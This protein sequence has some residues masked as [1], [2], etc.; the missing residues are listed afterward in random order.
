MLN[1]TSYLDK[2]AA[3]AKEALIKSYLLLAEEKIVEMIQTGTPMM[4]TDT[5]EQFEKLLKEVRMYSI[6]SFVFTCPEFVE[7]VKAE[8]EGNRMSIYGRSIVEYKNARD[9]WFSSR[10]E[11][12][13]NVKENN[14][15][16]GYKAKSQEQLN[17]QAVKYANDTWAVWIKKMT[18]KLDG[19]NIVAL[20]TLGNDPLNNTMIAE[21]LNGLRFTVNNSI[22]L[23]I[24]DKGTI[25]N[26]FPCRF[27]VPM[28]NGKKIKGASSQ[29]AI[30]ELAVFLVP[31]QPRCLT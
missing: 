17:E 31:M 11:F 21:C 22:E 1:I 4:E 6:A 24:N 29:V 26:R 25:F 10:K 9:A 20:E 23:V 12:F 18:V 15:T 28:V 14:R 3:P 2:S 7:K 13:N 5:Q 30:K 16:V 27:S 8:V 19:M